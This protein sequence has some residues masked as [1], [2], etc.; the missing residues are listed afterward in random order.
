MKHIYILLAVFMLMSVA[1]KAQHVEKEAPE[2]FDVL[3]PN[4]AHVN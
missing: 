2:G 3:Q 4:I 1:A